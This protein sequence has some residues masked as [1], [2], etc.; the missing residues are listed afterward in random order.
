MSDG[1]SDQSR[2]LR[3]ACSA[4]MYRIFGHLMFATDQQRSMLVSDLAEYLSVGEQ[5]VN[6][7]LSE[8]G[9][10]DRVPRTSELVDRI[11]AWARRSA[12]S[13]ARGQRSAPDNEKGELEQ[14]LAA[15]KKLYTAAKSI[16]LKDNDWVQNNWPDLLYFID[17][18]EFLSAPLWKLVAEGSDLSASP[19]A[20]S[21]KSRRPPDLWSD[22]PVEPAIF[23]LLSWRV[24]L[25]RLYGRDAELNNL[26]D[27][28]HGEPGAP[29][30][31]I[32]TGPGGI[33][34]S[35]LAAELC[36]S[37]LDENWEIRFGNHLEFDTSGGARTL[38]IIDYPEEQ[39]R[40]LGTF[41]R[42]LRGAYSPTRLVRV[43]ML[44]RQ[45]SEWWS[46][47][48]EVTRARADHL[49]DTLDLPLHEL[50]VD[51]SVLMFQEAWDS[52]C[53][54][55]GELPLTLT[56]GALEREFAK[57]ELAT[58]L[59]IVATALNLYL[60]NGASFTTM[61]SALVDQLIRRERSRL[62]SLANEACS[63]LGF[64]SDALDPSW[65]SR[66]YGL[67]ALTYGTSISQLRRMAHPSLEMGLPPPNR[68]VDIVRR[69]PFYED[70]L[71]SPKIAVPRPD[72]FAAGLLFQILTE[73]PDQ[74]GE[75]LWAARP[76][77]TAG[78]ADV[79]DRLGRLIH[80]IKLLC[81]PKDERLDEWLVAMVKADHSRASM[82][83]GI[84]YDD[85]PPNTSL[86][87]AISTNRILS[88]SIEDPLQ[89]ALHL[90]FLALHL[91]W[92]NKT[93]LAKR[94]A[95]QAV[96]IIRNESPDDKATLGSTLRVLAVANHEPD[97][98]QEAVEIFQEISKNDASVSNRL[99]EVRA[100]NALG[101]ALRSQGDSENER[102]A[103]EQMIS[104]CRELI[105]KNVRSRQYEVQD[106]L[107]RGLFNL[108]TTIKPGEE[109]L[110]FIRESVE[111]RRE[112]ASKRPWRY[113]RYYALSLTQLQRQ[114]LDAALFEE[115]LEVAKICLNV[116]R[117]LANSDPHFVYDFRRQVTI[118]G[119]AT[120]CVASTRAR[121]FAWLKDIERLMSEGLSIPFLLQ[122][123][124][125]YSSMLQIQDSIFI[126]LFEFGKS[127]AV[128]N[129]YDNGRQAWYLN[130]LGYYA[131]EYG[132]EVGS[133]D[134]VEQAIPILRTAIENSSSL[135]SESYA[136]SLHSLG[137]ALMIR[138][139]LN[140]SVSDNEECRSLFTQALMIFH[141]NKSKR[142]A[143]QVDRDSER[144]KSIVGD[145]V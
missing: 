79:G 128:L 97:V 123:L 29:R 41:L 126:K 32:V 143:D 75:W 66:I 91:C 51:E 23:Q 113:T 105:S 88:E 92:A 94:P 119:L 53:R 19:R 71:N 141:E 115:Y 30:V 10:N 7:W 98:A 145:A 83:A 40:E 2:R 109:A 8:R 54:L 26:L 125:L 140:E 137:Y 130:E 28:V 15:Y 65:A 49:F 89:K 108:S 43:L 57:G 38:W 50:G 107:A 42:T 14:E 134:I 77:P 111:I 34:K 44:S 99:D 122:E 39:Q 104:I 85:R 117:T 110:T 17:T 62:D 76:E 87:L 86:E 95:A 129:E 139:E 144:L 24:R 59:M 9:T 133:L 61:G 16:R 22:P 118:T 56:Q 47:N 11:I 81:D 131:A 12:E 93:Y 67:S 6:S 116:R 103:F 31:R 45:P 138:M 58:P 100:L 18:P 106:D 69:L 136:M 84:I 74:A 102:S 3:Q 63:M 101:L 60:S 114:L 25:T 68:I 124:K 4:S 13:V 36:E 112:L 127:D 33:G 80:D 46:E 73:R 37:L 135:D 120:V 82:L 142:H 48:E 70:N 20:K 55:Y 96:A 64:G 21:H 52:L 132:D 27:W 90:K 1:V 121:P 5:S 72:L 78:S 35:R